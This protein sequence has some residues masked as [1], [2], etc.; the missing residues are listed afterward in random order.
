[1]TRIFLSHSSTDKPMVRKLAGDLLSWGIDVWLDEWKINPGDSII[2]LVQR[3]VE[4][5]DFVGIWLTTNSIKSSWVEREWR[6]KL[7]QEIGLD[8]VSVIP[9][10]YESVKLPLFLAEKKYADFRKNYIDGLFDLSKSI[11]CHLE[12]QESMI[13]NLQ[14]DW[15]GKSPGP[16]KMHFTIQGND[17]NGSYEW[18]P[19]RTG[20][21]IGKIKDGRILCRWFNAGDGCA[22]FQQ[23]GN[24]IS[25]IW[26]STGFGPSYFELL[27]G[28]SRS[29]ENQHQERQMYELQAG[30][31]FPLAVLP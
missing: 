6:T 27:R 24:H 23:E 15:V 26:W 20:I 22:I 30:I 14:G 2:Q 5:S 3:G 16:I 29:F 31:E 12:F 13:L 28:C 4:E 7:F 21:L 10:L 18:L 8:R 1:M 9:L 25:G 19:L 11:N 17:V